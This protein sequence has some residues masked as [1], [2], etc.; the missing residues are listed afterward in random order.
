MPVRSVIIGSDH[1][2]VDLKK[3]LVK[4]LRSMGLQVHDFGVRTRRP[5][6]YPDVARPVA[7]A[8][9]RGDYDRGILICGTGIGMSM[10]ANRVPGARC[11]ACGG[12]FQAE[13]SRLHNDANIL[14]LGARTVG[15]ELAVAVMKRWLETGFEGGRHERR[16]TKIEAG[17]R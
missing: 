16:I 10:A 13:I 12:L 9:A 7:E 17:S 3:R 5:A 14:A 4:E 6:D 15:E 2:G 1:A 11:A 8:V